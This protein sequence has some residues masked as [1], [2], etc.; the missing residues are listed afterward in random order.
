MKAKR[1]L[2]G[3]GIGIIVSNVETEEALRSLLDFSLH[4]GQ[5]Y[6]FGRPDK[7]DHYI[8]APDLKAG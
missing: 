2:E 1:V 7:A 3:N 4:Y 6:L 8:D 5:G